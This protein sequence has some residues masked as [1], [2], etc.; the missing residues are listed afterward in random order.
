MLCLVFPCTKAQIWVAVHLPLVLL[1][2][3]SHHENK[4]KILSFYRDILWNFEGK[5]INSVY[6]ACYN[7][8]CIHTYIF[9]VHTLLYNF[10][11]IFVFKSQVNARVKWSNG[12]TKKLH[13][14]V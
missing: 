7:Y 14:V 8:M 5:E 6:T 12:L 13:V 4:F 3:E 11:I 2:S 9:V 1:P 10:I